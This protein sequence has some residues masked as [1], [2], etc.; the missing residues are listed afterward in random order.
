MREFD[1]SSPCEFESGQMVWARVGGAPFWPSVIVADPDLLLSTRVAAKGS[2]LS[3]EYHVQFFGK[4][5]QRA[6]VASSALLPFSGLAAF[7]EKAREVK[8]EVGRAKT[9]QKLLK[10]YNPSGSH[11]RAWDD[12]VQEAEDS[13]KYS[14]GETRATHMKK[15]L[16]RSLTARKRKLTHDDDSPEGQ[17]RLLSAAVSSSL[18]VECFSRIFAN[19]RI[20]K[21]TT[22]TFQMFLFTSAVFQCSVSCFLLPSSKWE[23]IDP[24]YFTPPVHWH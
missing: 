15:L 8:D 20:S 19:Q 1:A 14:D 17:G 22:Y 9:K 10:A 23:P 21:S 11:R 4:A 18:W 24:D 13:F 5:V 12:A 2:S 7:L 6:W 3:R 16:E